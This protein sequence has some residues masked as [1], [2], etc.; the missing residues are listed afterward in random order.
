MPVDHYVVLY[1]PNEEKAV[2][3]VIRVM[4]GGR[5]IEKQLN[6]YTAFQ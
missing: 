4:Y 1:I 6:K 3:T 5:D 2:V